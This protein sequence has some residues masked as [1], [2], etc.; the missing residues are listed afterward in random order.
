MSLASYHCSTP[1]PITTALLGGRR[2]ALAAAVPL[3]DPRRRE[4][5]ELVSDHVLGHVQPHE[6]PAV[7]DQERLPDE[8]RHDRA[9]AGPG[10]DRLAAAGALLPLHLAHQALVDVGPFFQRPAHEGDLIQRLDILRPARGPASPRAL[11]LGV[12]RAGPAA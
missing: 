7:V 5:A 12:V 2:L 4:L 10:L 8:L 11:F 6:L 9:V 3:E 1:G